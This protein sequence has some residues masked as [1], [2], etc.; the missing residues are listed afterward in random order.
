MAEQI[1]RWGIM[2]T[3]TIAHTFADALRAVNG[4]ELLAVGSRSLERANS[5]G[6]EFGIP[7]RY[8]DYEALV[9]DPDI[10]VIYIGTPHS[11][12]Y[13]DVMLCLAAGKHVL[14]EKPLTI[15]AVEA[16][17]LIARARAQRLFLM[18]AMWTRFLPGARAL[19]ER[20][21]LGDIGDVRVFQADFL[22]Y[23]PF[24]AK[25]R[26]FNPELGGGAL[27]DLGVYP[28]AFAFMLMGEPG[29]AT[30]LAT[31]GSTGVD[32]QMSAVLMYPNGA[33]ANI[34]AGFQ[35]YGA[36]RA[37]IAGTRGR[38]EIEAH[39][40]RPERFLVYIEDREPQRYD[41]KVTGNPYRYEAQ[42]VTDCIRLGR[43]ESALM[44]LAESLAIMRTMD[45][46]RAQWGLRYPADK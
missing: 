10:D 34:T 22:T 16:A 20:V 18:E 41:Y 25:H 15:N 23:R 24:E 8:G 9:G 30:S 2:S 37:S 31:I 44:P 39:F 35:A 38:V 43:L 14:C 42:E 1:I 12:H 4:V 6:D 11:R 32:E 3:G 13:E 5:F 33:L 26:L 7:R 40:Y 28:I 21:A 19:R 36:Q 17:E 45:S 29:R 27:L 46:L